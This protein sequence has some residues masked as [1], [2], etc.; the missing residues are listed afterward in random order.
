MVKAQAMM[1]IKKTM[2]KTHD[3]Y[4]VAEIVSGCC[5][6]KYYGVVPVIRYPELQCPACLEMSNP[7]RVDVLETN[8]K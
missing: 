4:V 8:D 3:G 1:K 6:Y 5:K 2:T 7:A